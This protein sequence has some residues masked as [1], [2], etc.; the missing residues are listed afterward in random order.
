MKSPTESIAPDLMSR[1]MFYFDTG[2]TAGL[3]LMKTKRARQSKT[4]SLT[5]GTFAFYCREEI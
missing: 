3:A 1:V 5:A 2:K 4:H